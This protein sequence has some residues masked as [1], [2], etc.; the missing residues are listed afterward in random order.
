[1]VARIKSGKNIRGL[2]NYNENKV[3]AGS[4]QLIMA[5]LFGTEL[6]KLNFS[7]KLNRFQHLTELNDRTKTNSVHIMLNF[8]ENEKPNTLTMQQIA[9]AYMDKIGFGDQPYLVYNHNDAAH[10]HIHIV[11]TN[12]ET[13]GNRIGLH[14]IGKTLSETARK[15]LEIEFGLVKADSKTLKQ[16]N[17]M[18]SVAPEKAVYGKT[19]TKRAITNVVSAVVSQYNF[20]SLPEFNAILKQFNVIA[21]RGKEDTLMFEKKGLIYSILDEKGNKIGVPFKASSLN[22]KPTLKNL[23]VRFAQNEEKRKPF[24]ESLKGNIEKVFRNYNGITKDTFIKELQEQNIQAVFRQNEQ[25]I[26]YGVTF[27]DNYNKTV[28]NGSDLGK[29]YTAKGLNEKFDTIDHPVKNKQ[30]NYSTTTQRNPTYLQNTPKTDYLKSDEP[31]EQY[32]QRSAFDKLLNNL[33]D[34]GGDGGAPLV[35]RKKKKGQ[36]R[37]KGL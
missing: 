27:I 28:F 36:E 32:L 35:T 16:A 7:D 14:N 10:T 26:I 13:D 4:A 8:D 19:P 20:T 33:M 22:D 6:E 1:M 15:E 5:S 12:I 24:K 25:G 17:C 9:A 18:K 2:L 11:T 21:D 23:E 29:A 3:T 31:T 37:G 30:D 34:K